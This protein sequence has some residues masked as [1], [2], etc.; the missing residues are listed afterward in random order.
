MY[1][2]GDLARRRPDGAL[3]FAG[4]VDDQVK[5][6]GYR[7]E[8][9]EVEHVLCGHPR[10]REAA[11]L[12]VG[13]GDAVRLVALVVPYG[14]LPGRELREYASGLLPDYLVPSA[15]V[16]LTEI[17]GNGRGKRDVAE[18]R[19]IAEEQLRRSREQ[20]APRDDVERYLAGLW[21][22]LLMAEHV[23]VTDDF[24]ALGGNS[25]LAFRLQRRISRDLGVPIEPLDVLTT[26]RLDGLADLIRDRRDAP[27][28]AQLPTP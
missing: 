20:I 16:F 12:A 18:L 9:Q 14:D 25:L 7:V 17:P 19:R 4:R 28:H 10:V 2:T 24:F 3:L 26:S 1:A 5:I 6:R 13:E 11:V 27:A 23:S 8:P 22:E 15:L 21:E